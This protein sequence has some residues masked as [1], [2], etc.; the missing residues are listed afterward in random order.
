MARETQED[1]LRGL[2]FDDHNDFA[3]YYVTSSSHS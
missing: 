1:Y 2:F 3:D